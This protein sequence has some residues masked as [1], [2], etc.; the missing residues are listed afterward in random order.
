M[1]QIFALIFVMF[2]GCFF[3]VS[4]WASVTCEQQ[5]ESLFPSREGV[6]VKRAEMLRECTRKEFGFLPVM[7]EYWAYFI[8]VASEVDT[9]RMTP[10]KG[11]Y[12]IAQKKNELLNNNSRVEL[13]QPPPTYKTNCSTLGGYTNCTTAPSGGRFGDPNGPRFGGY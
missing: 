9:G 2:F 7:E 11:N 3:S 8:Y 4:A 12:L 13:Q 1:N 5:V 10:E 6:R